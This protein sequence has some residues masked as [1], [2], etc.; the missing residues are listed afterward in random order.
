M[1]TAAREKLAA[2]ELSADAPRPDNVRTFVARV[3]VG[4]RMVTVSPPSPP[5]L[6]LCPTPYGQVSA[7]VGNNMY[8]VELPSG[9]MV[10]S[11]MPA[12]LRGRIYIM[13]GAMAVQLRATVYDDGSTRSPVAPRQL[14]RRGDS[15]RQPEA[16]LARPSGDA[17]HSAAGTRRRA[18]GR[19]LLARPVRLG[20][21]PPQQGNQ[22]RTGRSRVCGALDHVHVHSGAWLI[23]VPRTYSSLLPP[24]DSDEE[25]NDDEEDVN[26]QGQDMDDADANMVRTHNPN[27]A[28][29]PAHHSDQDADDDNADEDDHRD[30]ES[31]AE[32]AP[33]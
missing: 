4:R 29:A 26:S 14:C 27:R 28:V 20:D 22:R 19:Q 5:A 9:E 1:S 10:L 21:C 16:Q 12:K 33:S 6:T 30:D 31:D 8:Q 18:Q 32:P 3:R 15:G 7:P 2:R 13:R 25:D 24:S 17:Q 23:R 11:M